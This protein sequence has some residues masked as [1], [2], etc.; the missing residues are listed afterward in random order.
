MSGYHEASLPVRA[1]LVR[2]R[3]FA[4]HKVDR[5]ARDD[6]ALDTL[7]AHGYGL[8]ALPGR[9]GHDAATTC[10]SIPKTGKEPQ[11]RLPISSG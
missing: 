4:T 10:V 6:H 7:N 9:S 5:Q 11:P 2:C 8:A 1:P 3:G